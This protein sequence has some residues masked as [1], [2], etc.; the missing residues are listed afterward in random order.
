MRIIDTVIGIT[1]VGG[2]FSY[3]LIECFR[4]QNDFRAKV[5]GFDSDPKATGRFFCDK[6]QVIPSAKYDP[7]GFINLVIDSCIQNSVDLFIP[8]SE[9]ECKAVVDNI[10]IFRLNS[11][12]VS[13]GNTD[14]VGIMTDKFSFMHF[15][16]EK[17]IE[18]GSFY[19]IHSLNDILDSLHNLDYPKSKVVLKPR[20]G[21]G[22]RGVLVLD[23]SLESVNEIIPD[24]N[25]VE[26][27][28]DSVLE[29]A[30]NKEIDFTFYMAMEYYSGDVYDIDCVAKNGKAVNVVPRLRK[31]D[32]PLSPFSEGCVISQDKKIIKYVSD[33]VLS[34]ECHGACDFDIAINSLG[35]PRVIDAST[36]LSGSVAASILAEINIPAQLVRIIKN[37]ELKEYY[38]RD[39]VYVRPV[40][41]FIKLDDC[42][43]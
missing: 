37:M 5:I 32:N 28:L 27:N 17:G 15:L 19:P 3:E 43:H 9:E 30:K 41:K 26:G 34:L 21:A 29:Y 23:S 40:K 1:C 36:R 35:E 13:I 24:R 42:G 10:D 7:K 31:Y 25:C 20:N 2:H 11:I 16:S 12:D 4:N 8:S 33:I 6:F 39:Q 18:V 22:S 38:P 14:I